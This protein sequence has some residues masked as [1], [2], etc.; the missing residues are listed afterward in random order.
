MH[1]SKIFKEVFEN[2][3]KFSQNFPTNWVFRPNAR[4]IDAGFVKF[5]EK[6]A[7]I[8]NFSKICKEVVENFRKFSQ[9]FPTICVFVHTREK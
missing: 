2:F 8:M 7:K 3:R 1:F 4:K 5:F 9:D 6:Y